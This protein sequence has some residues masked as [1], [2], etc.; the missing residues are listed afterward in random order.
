M[1]PE[2]HTRNNAESQIRIQETKNQPKPTKQNVLLLSKHKYQQ[3]TNESFKISV[4]KL[5]LKK[6]L[7]L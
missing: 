3:L 4:K 2:C 1:D 7:F 6:I 5:N